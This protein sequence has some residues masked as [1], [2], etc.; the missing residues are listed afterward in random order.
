[1]V[2]PAVGAVVK[3]SV[4][5]PSVGQLSR[6]VGG[7][8]DAV[9]EQVVDAPVFTLNEDGQLLITGAVRSGKKIVNE[10]VDVLPFTSVTVSVIRV[11]GTDAAMIVPTGTSCVTLAI[12]QAS[13]LVSLEVRSVMVLV[14][15]IPLGIVVS[16]K[17][18]TVGGVMSFTVTVEVQVDVLPE[19][20]VTVRV[21]VLVPTL[22]Q[23]KL[24]LDKA[25][26]TGEQLS[27]LPLS[28]LEGSSVAVPLAARLS[29]NGLHAAVGGVW[30]TRF[31]RKLVLSI[32]PQISVAVITIVLN[33]PKPITAE[34]GTLG[35]SCCTVI[36]PVQ[37]SVIVT[38][39]L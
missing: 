39:P 26:V 20:S 2:R 28:I 35:A 32:L 9:A 15:L 23:S 34:P 16:P 36:G 8:Q 30:S 31:K 14:Q 38:R 7:V 11:D 22:E 18:V 5:V 25:K 3:V 24:D 17:Q 4:V 37:L 13:D 1:L 6:A 29:V 10:Q 12:P 21:T 19:A 33:P 27:K